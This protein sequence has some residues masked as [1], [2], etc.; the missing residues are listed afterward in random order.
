MY[1]LHPCD[2]QELLV[3]LKPVVSHTSQKLTG[4]KYGHQSTIERFLRIIDSA[5]RL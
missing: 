5:M 1:H 4:T 3:S 2:A